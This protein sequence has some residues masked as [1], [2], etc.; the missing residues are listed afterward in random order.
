MFIIKFFADLIGKKSFS[1]F[2]SEPLALLLFGIVL[3]AVTTGLRSFL[4]GQDKNTEKMMEEVK[5]AVVINKD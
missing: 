3:F 2:I 5:E 4:N 1:G